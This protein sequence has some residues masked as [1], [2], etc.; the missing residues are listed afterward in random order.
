MR[1]RQIGFSL[2]ACVP[3]IGI[4]FATRNVDFLVGFTGSYA[5]LC[6]MFVIPALLVMYARR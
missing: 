5:G 2:L 4:A 1:A 6:I 3:P